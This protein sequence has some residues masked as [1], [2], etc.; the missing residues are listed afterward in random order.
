MQVNL[1]NPTLDAPPT[2]PQPNA[3]RSS[4]CNVGYST[5]YHAKSPSMIRM[6]KSQNQQ[7]I[8]RILVAISKSLDDLPTRSSVPMDRA[9]SYNHQRGP[10][11]LWPSLLLGAKHQFP[12]Q[13]LLWRRKTQKLLVANDGRG[14]PCCRESTKLA[15]F[16][17][18]KPTLHMDPNL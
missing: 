3:Q 12:D 9:H 6:S 14:V 7:R 13:A 15:Y 11:N 2:H 4:I 17:E 1:V 18:A 5:Q 10:L 8:N 16:Q